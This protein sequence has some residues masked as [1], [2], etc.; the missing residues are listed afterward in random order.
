MRMTGS[1]RPEGGT[2]RCGAY[3]RVYANVPEYPGG[4]AIARQH[5]AVRDLPA[6]PFAPD[7]ADRG[8]ART[9]RLPQLR[10][11]VG[12]D[13]AEVTVFERHSLM[14]HTIPPPR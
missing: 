13:H 8:H 6:S 1:A 3:F 14:R 10:L 5:R 7:R 2:L 11:R 9:F 12:P 4:S